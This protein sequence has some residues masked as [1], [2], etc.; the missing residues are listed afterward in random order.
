MRRWPALRKYGLLDGD[1]EAQSQVG[2]VAVVR[3]GVQAE[4]GEVF[5]SNVRHFHEKLGS[6]HQESR[7]LHLSQQGPARSL[8]ERSGSASADAAFDASG[9]AVPLPGMLLHIDGSRI[10]GFKMI[11]GMTCWAILDDAT[12]R[13]DYGQLVEAESTPV[14]VEPPRRPAVI[15]EFRTRAAR[16]CSSERSGDCR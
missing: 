2:A 3:A 6:Q 8:A 16:D 10:T 7:E 15:Q 5:R 1:G 11:A 13:M 12:I 14:W 4:S 9:S